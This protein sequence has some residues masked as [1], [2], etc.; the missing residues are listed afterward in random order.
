MRSR[1]AIVAQT[2]R[3]HTFRFAHMTVKGYAKNNPHWQHFR[4][5]T[6]P[7]SCF[8]CENGTA[9][10]CRYEDIKKWQN[11]VY[12]LQIFQV[13]ATITVKSQAANYLVSLPIHC[14]R[15]RLQ[16][17]HVNVNSH[18]LYGNAEKSFACNLDFFHVNHNI[19]TPFTFFSFSLD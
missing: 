18:R 13:I 1:D 19:L 17:R 12:K 16:C 9:T 14:H 2:Q 11:S 6:P 8:A 7:L 10:P 4:P 5:P 3:T 15:I